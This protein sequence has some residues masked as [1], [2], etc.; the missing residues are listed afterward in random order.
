VPQTVLDSQDPKSL[1]AESLNLK[2]LL[3]AQIPEVAAQEPNVMLLIASVPS[4][5]D[6]Q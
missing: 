4:I 2:N 1:F 6:M 5:Q 3:A